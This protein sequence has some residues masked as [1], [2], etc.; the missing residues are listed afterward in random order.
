MVKLKKPNAITGMLGD[1]VAR[2]PE[3]AEAF[4]AIVSSAPQERPAL[5]KD[6]A[7]IEAECDESYLTLFRKVAETFITPYDREDIYSMIETLDDVIDTLDNAGR[8]I[9]DFE[10]QEIPEELIRNAK[11]LVVMAELARD[12]TDLIKKPKKMEKILLA[13]NEHE[14][15]MDAG[16][17]G[18]LRTTLTPG[19]DPVTAI[20]I[21]I[22]ADAVEEVAT[23]IESFVRNLSI[24]AIKET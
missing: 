24:T 20:K 16:Y 19:A 6:L 8:L 10:F 21:K 22:L 15:L 18:T 9:I 12:A 13:I 11:E 2:L 17:R 4:Y 23:L 3:A 7:R 1:A 5:V 14:N